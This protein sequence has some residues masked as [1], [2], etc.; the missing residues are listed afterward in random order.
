MKTIRISSEKIPATF[1]RYQYRAE[2]ATAWKCEAD[3]IGISEV[4]AVTVKRKEL[5]PD[6]QLVE[7]ET[8]TEAEILIFIPD[9]LKAV[10]AESI[11]AAHVATKSGQAQDNEAALSIAGK[12][13]DIE[14]RLQ[15]LEAASK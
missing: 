1:N 5:G 14:M 6:G 2:L 7:S 8:T 11:L 4:G 12:F 13:A 3:Q 9:D 15:A 10:N